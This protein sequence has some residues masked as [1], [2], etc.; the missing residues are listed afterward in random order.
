MALIIIEKCC[1]CGGENLE[2]YEKFN[3]ICREC[4]RKRISRKAGKQ[5]LQA[6]EYKGGKCSICGYNEFPSAMD[7]HHLDPKVKEFS[8]QRARYRPFEEIKEELDKCIL[9]CARCHREIHATEQ[10]V[11][12]YKPMKQRIYDSKSEYEC[13]QCGK[14]F[15]GSS[16]KNRIY[17]SKECASKSIAEKCSKVENKP[18]KE[19][20]QELIDSKPWTTIGDMFGVSDNAVRKWIRSYNLVK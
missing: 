18:N 11:K 1:D 17:C 8:L 5:K 19:Q 12:D 16:I 6:I 2:A 14:K 4:H 15:E 7:F 3:R 13:K 10:L 20:L 9:V